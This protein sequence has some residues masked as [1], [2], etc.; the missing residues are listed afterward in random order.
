MNTSLTLG[1]LI[2]EARDR[3]GLTRAE[4]ARRARTSPSSIAR[5]ETGRSSPKIETAQRCVDA[6]GFELR[7]EPSHVSPQRQAATDAAFSRSAED[8]LRTNDAFTALAARLRN[9]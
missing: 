8:R 4:L 3:A 9:G 6:C 5:Y 1:A 7:V 2:R